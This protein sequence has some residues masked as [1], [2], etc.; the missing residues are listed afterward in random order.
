MGSRLPR[1]LEGVGRTDTLSKGAQKALANMRTQYGV[2]E[3][4][5]IYKQKAEEQGEGNTL[6]QKVNSTYHKGAK[7]K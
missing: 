6:R 4:H 2:K 3:G 7:L 5:R 1:Q